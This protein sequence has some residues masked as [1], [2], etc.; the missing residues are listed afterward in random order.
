MPDKICSS[1]SLMEAFGF[2]NVL[3][4]LFIQGDREFP[5]FCQGAESCVEKGKQNIAT[6]KNVQRDHTQGFQKSV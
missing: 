1:L 5:F 6:H 3:Q 4:L 2:Q